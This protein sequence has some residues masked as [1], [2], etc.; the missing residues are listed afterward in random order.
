MPRPHG[1]AAQCIAG[2]CLSIR[3]PVPDP[4]SRMQV[5]SKVKIGRKEQVYP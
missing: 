2:R 5:R 1:V 3:P 4:K